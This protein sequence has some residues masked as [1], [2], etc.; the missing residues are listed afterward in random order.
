MADRGDDAHP[1]P[2]PAPAARGDGCVQVVVTASSAEEAT[3][4]GRLAVQHRR[5]AC[6]QVS[7]PI[8]S[9]Y[10]WGGELETAAEWVC[11]LKTVEGE[12][13]ALVE[14]LRRAHSYQVP[15]IV[16]VP[17]TG[18]DPDYLAWVQAQTSGAA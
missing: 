18:G 3:S 11:V 14:E 9:T 2:A 7:G 10:W 5:A 6:A 1:A 15:E 16:V 13:P 17:L 8:S 12:L 4:L